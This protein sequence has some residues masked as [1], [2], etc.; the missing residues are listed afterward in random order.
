MPI[1]GSRDGNKSTHPRV[2]GLDTT[3]AHVLTVAPRQPEFVAIMTDRAYQRQLQQPP[4]KSEASMLPGMNVGA[5]T[6]D[7]LPLGGFQVQPGHQHFGWR[8]VFPAIKLVNV[9]QAQTVSR[10]IGQLVD[11]GTAQRAGTIVVKRILIHSDYTCEISSQ[12]CRAR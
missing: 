4:E 3:T 12:I 7:P 10:Q 11:F 8:A 1:T 6:R 2:D 9:L 5:Q